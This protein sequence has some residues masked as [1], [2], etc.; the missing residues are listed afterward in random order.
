MVAGLAWGP[1][2]APIRST[3]RYPRAG[4]GSSGRLPAAAG[5]AR[6]GDGASAI[7]VAFVGSLYDRDGRTALAAPE[8]ARAVLE[9]YRNRGL[10]T[11]AELRG[12]YALAVWDGRSESLHAATDPFRTHPLFYAEDSDGVRVSSR[13][14]SLLAGLDP[15]AHPIDPR[16]VV[17]VVAFSYIPAPRTARR[18]V[19]KVPAA[20]V[21]T[22][23]HGEVSVRPYWDFDFLHPSTDSCRDLTGRL[24]DT[25]RGSVAARLRADEGVASVG[26][27]LSGGVDSSTVTGLVGAI[28]GAPARCFSIG[29]GEQGYN[30]L[31]YARIASRHLGAAYH[32]RLVAASDVPAIL[33]LLLEAFDEPYGNASAVPTYACARFARETGIDVLY[34][35]DG[36]DELFAGNQRYASRRVFDRYE[37]VPGWIRSSLLEP[38]VF[39]AARLVPVNAVQRAKRYILRAKT[40]HFDRMTGYD[41]LRLHPIATLFQDDVV[42]ALGT[43]YDPYEEARAHYEN[44]PARTALD[45]ELYLD[46]KMTISD[47]DVVKVTRMCEAAGVTVRFP[48]LDGAVASFATSVPASLKMRG[49]KLRWFF[50]QAYPD[51]LPPEVRAKKKHGFG[52]PIAVWLRSDPTLR[53]MLH[54]LVLGADGR[55]AAYLRRPALE[56][57]VRRHESDTT[58]FYGTILWN[59]LVLELHLRAAGGSAA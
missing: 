43:P 15:S 25:L 23:R 7:G 55:A 19:R 26:T 54:D 35:G 45:R 4:L 5:L 49:G 38:A 2:H 8:A 13:I 11:L 3:A 59:V 31:E 52:L 27:F 18:G 30:E 20:H 39:T 42:S 57:L 32:Q 29:F 34:A 56:D 47:N 16:A 44:A 48:F 24:R 28:T 22:A 36:G 12:E 37:R 46:L 6:S 10:D 33:P 40:S 14:R 21:L 58:Q 17:D 41:L 50:K 53:A 9:S 51:L 1:D